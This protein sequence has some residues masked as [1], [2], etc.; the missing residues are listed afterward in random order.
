MQDLTEIKKKLAELEKKVDDNLKAIDERFKL[1]YTKTEIKSLLKD[2]EIVKKAKLE[3]GRKNTSNSN[4]KPRG[5]GHRATVEIPTAS[6]SP[7][8]DVEIIDDEDDEN[9]FM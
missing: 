9:P 1:Y 4:S 6:D 5:L 7:F 3:K 2:F 8:D